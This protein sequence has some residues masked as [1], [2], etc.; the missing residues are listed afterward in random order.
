[1]VSL[2]YWI[3]SLKHPI[4]PLYLMSEAVELNEMKLL[5][6]LFSALKVIGTQKVVCPS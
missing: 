4:Q 1:M 6:G 3:L 2:R 5:K